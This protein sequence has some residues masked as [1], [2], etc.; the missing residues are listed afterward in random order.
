MMETPEKSRNTT[1]III[2]V[3]VGLFL[4]CSCVCAGFTLIGIGGVSQQIISAPKA[5]YEEC[6]SLTDSQQC[7]ACCKLHGHNGNM[8]GAMLNDSGH[9]CGCL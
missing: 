6:Q 8:L 2:A 7:Q 3:V 4:L 9:T 5:Y 1:V